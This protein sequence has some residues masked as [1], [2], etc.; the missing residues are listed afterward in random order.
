MAKGSEDNIRL[1]DLKLNED[2]PRKITRAGM[3]SLKNNLESFLKGLEINGIVID[4]NNVIK[5]GNQRY[6]ALLE[7]GYTKIPKK[8]V[9]QFKDL[10]PGEWK[11]YVIID[12]QHFGF[13]DDEVLL[14][15]YEPAVLKGMGI[16]IKPKADPVKP[17]IEF[18]P[19]LMLEHNYV[20]LYFDNAMDWEVAKDKL[21]LKEVKSAIKTVKS[22]KV[23]IG[24]V[25]K[26]APVINRL[27]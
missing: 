17:E 15:Q 8:W 24:R 19:E 25:I 12:N 6:K 2:N 27:K 22:Q 16:D 18:S 14:S 5:G 3:D 21:G 9:R 10:S 11:Q 20:V 4:E 7:L 23:G 13:W 26:G 1:E